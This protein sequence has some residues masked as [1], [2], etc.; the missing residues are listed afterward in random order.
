MARYS[1]RP[2]SLTG[3]ILLG[4]VIV[5]LPALLG[6]V[7][8]AIEIRKLSA[9]SERLV[10]NGIAA[11]QYTQ[12]LVRQVSSLERTVRLYQIIPRP[13]LLDTFRQNRDLTTRTLQEFAAL[14][15]GGAD[16]GE[17]IGRMQ[18]SVDKVAAAIDSGSATELTRTLREFTDMSRDAGKLSNLAGAQ[19]DRE[20]KQLQSETDAVRRRLYWQSAALIPVTAGLIIMFALFLARPIRQIDAAIGN[21]GHGLLTEPVAV[22]GPSDLKALGRQLEWLR[23][24]LLE[25]S[26]ERNRFLRHMSHELKTPLANIREGSELLFEGA[27]GSLSG[28][29]REVAGILRDNSLRLQRLIENLLSYSEWQTRR[30]ALELAEIRLLP[31]VKAAIETYQLPV[32]ARGLR[33]DLQVPDLTLVGDREKLKLI[34]DNLMSNAVKFTPDG[35]TITLRAGYDDRGRHLLFEVADTG[36][37]I[38]VEERPRIFEAF[39]Q[40]ATPHGGLVRGTGIGLSVVQEFVHAHG[41]DIEIVDGEFPGAHFRL[42]LP[43]SPNAA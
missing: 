38:P 34:L 28:E 29:Q 18:H 32:N 17:V 37:G 30:S 41:G 42:R 7:S 22:Q 1:F 3:L 36:P 16:R 31:L 4:F 26:E 25:I 6:T 20:L 21:I 2:R 8:A 27:V 19:T 39:Y 40:G 5:A 15:G 14:P 33:L 23:V 13:A 24:R 35:G 12:A 9:A 43:L 11:T 10:V